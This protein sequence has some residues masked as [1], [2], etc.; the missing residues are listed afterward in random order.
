M[1]SIFDQDNLLNAAE[2]RSIPLPNGL[3]KSVTMTRAG[4][5]S[6]D[7]LA[8][9]E[10][11][12]AE[13][14]ID[15]ADHIRGDDTKNCFGFWLEHAMMC[16]Q[17]GQRQDEQSLAAFNRFCARQPRNDEGIRRIEEEALRIKARR[18]SLYRN[19]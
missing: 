17:E 2:I 4:W 11:F 1:T 12:D 7:D 5:T 15:Y 8:G 18:D 16:V 9:D 3:V 19:L 6:F 14:L 10:F 13:T